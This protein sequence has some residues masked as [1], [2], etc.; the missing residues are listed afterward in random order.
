MHS[1]RKDVSTFRIACW[2]VTK[3]RNAT[4]GRAT[5]KAGAFLWKPTSMH[6]HQIARWRRPFHMECKIGFG[7]CSMRGGGKK[8]ICTY[9]LI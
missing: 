9:A 5:S 2:S 8:F 7:N 6:K 4:L 1:V 3:S